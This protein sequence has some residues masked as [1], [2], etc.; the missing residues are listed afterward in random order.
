[1]LE[2]KHPEQALAE[3]ETSLKNDPGRFNSLYGAAMAA[4][5]TGEVEIA[6][7]YFTQIVKNCAGSNSDRLEL[8]LAREES[9]KLT[10]AEA[11]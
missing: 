4:T 9:G 10:S 3:Y 6:K 11:R 5:S 7:R 8:K 2:S 1:L